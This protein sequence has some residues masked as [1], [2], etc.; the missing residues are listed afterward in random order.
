MDYLTYPTTT[1]TMRA[2]R[3]LLGGGVAVRV[4]SRPRGLAGNCSLALRLPPG[5]LEL[6]LQLLAAAR[7]PQPRRHSVSDR[8]GKT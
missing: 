4:R 5:G 6:S 8:E 2:E 3:V 1:L 7:M